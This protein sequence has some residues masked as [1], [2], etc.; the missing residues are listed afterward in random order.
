MLRLGYLLAP[1]AGSRIPSTY[2]SYIYTH[3]YNY[4]FAD[5]HE[6]LFI[7]GN[8]CA[9]S[10]RPIYAAY[11]LEP[12]PAP[13]KMAFSTVRI[14]EALVLCTEDLLLSRIGL[15]TRGRFAAL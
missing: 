11:L 1:P 3:I 14:P 15:G 10:T 12:D 6:N 8:S 13:G 4:I 9:V 2:T 7:C 5:I